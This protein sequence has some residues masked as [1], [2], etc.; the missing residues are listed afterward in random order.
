[1]PCSICKKRGHTR[2]TCNKKA[3][4]VLKPIVSELKDNIKVI[5]QKVKM[6]AQEYNAM[7]SEIRSVAKSIE[8]SKERGG[9]GRIDSVIKESPF[10]LELKRVLLEKHPDWDIVIES[11]RAYCD[12]SI[13]S[14]PI[15]L[16]LTDCKSS[17]NSGN[18]RS[19]Y[20]SVTGD[21]TYPYSSNWNDFI[22]RLE[23]NKNLIKKRRDKLTEYH[24]LV[25]NK[26]TGDV[27]MKSI[28][29]I[30]TYNSNPSNILQ[31]NWKNEFS[32]SDYHTEDEDYVNKS[33]SLINCIQK[34]VT[35]MNERSKRFV[36][37]NLNL[38]FS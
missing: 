21:N 22:D 34:S 1:M 12:I 11:S 37:A 35:E 3:N 18:K 20:Y 27:L 17:D 2:R 19:I 23:K 31:I 28:F 9:D 30:H 26:I 33:K 10:L 4:T 32:Y 7:I 6:A 24:Y 38:L 14:I 16:K 8:L 15:N 5:P 25:K 36:E 13:N 29:D